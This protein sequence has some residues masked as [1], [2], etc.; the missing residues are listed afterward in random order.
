LPVTSSATPDE[1]ADA[2]D[3]AE[4]VEVEV[5][6][7]LEAIELLEEVD[8]LLVPGLDDEPQAAAVARINAAGTAITIVWADFRIGVLR[9]VRGVRCIA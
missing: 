2:P 8:G 5:L 3:K 1:E 6:A 4:V 9:S 7:G